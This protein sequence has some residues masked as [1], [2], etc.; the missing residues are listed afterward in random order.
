[1]NNIDYKAVVQILEEFL[2][3]YNA[4]YPE[5]KEWVAIYPNQIQAI[6]NLIQ[7]NKELKKQLND[8]HSNF[9]K[10]N[11]QE[12][13]GKQVYNQ[14]AELYESIYRKENKNE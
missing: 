7:E 2:E 10:F 1:M 4:S 3:Q 11:W 13:N 14:L 9:C 8:I 5:E 12:S 6:E